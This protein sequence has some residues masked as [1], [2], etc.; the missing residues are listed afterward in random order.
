[1]QAPPPGGTEATLD[2]S[3]LIREIPQLQWTIIALADSAN[4]TRPCRIATGKTHAR[5]T[6][7]TIMTFST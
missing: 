3:T 5:D 2:L 6:M 7:N 4:A 1:M